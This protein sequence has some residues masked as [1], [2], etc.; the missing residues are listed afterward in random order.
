MVKVSRSPWDRWEFQIGGQKR[1]Y[2][3]LLKAG[4]VHSEKLRGEVMKHAMINVG[5][6][7]PSTAPMPG[8]VEAWAAMLE[9]CTIERSKCTSRNYVKGRMGLP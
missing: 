2:F 5:V 7:F 6:N 4:G 8:L 9:R 3:E 1:G